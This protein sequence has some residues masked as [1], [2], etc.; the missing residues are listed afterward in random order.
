LYDL[1][2]WYPLFCLIKKFAKVQ[3]LM[4]VCQQSET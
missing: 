2:M 3:N 1:L 4:S